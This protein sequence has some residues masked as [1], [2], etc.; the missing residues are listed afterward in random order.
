VSFRQIVSYDPAVSDESV[1]DDAYSYLRGHT[2]GDLQ[3]D[4]HMRP[5]RYVIANDGRL[6]AP[7][8][9]AMLESVDTVLFV[10]DCAQEAMEMMVTLVPLNERGPEGASADRWRI[11]H[12]EPEDVRWAFLSIDTARFSNLVIDGEALQRSNPLAAVESQICREMNQKP[13]DLRKLCARHGTMEVEQPRMVGIDP[14]GIDV[15][16]RFD[17]VRIAA[18]EPMNS[19]AEARRVLAAMIAKC[20]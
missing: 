19:A 5:L 13:D 12:G 4:E 6:V 9:V 10:P 14:L 8:M 15:R 2:R 17:V 11:Y 18:T 7:V 16:A 1:I 20:D 3:F